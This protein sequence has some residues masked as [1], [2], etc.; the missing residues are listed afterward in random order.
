[1]ILIAGGDLGAHLSEDVFQKISLMLLYYV[2]HQGDICS[3]KLSLRNRDYK[4]YLNSM[5]NLRSDEDRNY[6]SQNEMEDILE[7]I[8]KHLEIPEKQVKE[9]QRKTAVKTEWIP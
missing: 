5:L 6:F 8:R 2:T 1:M 3:S 4:F 9:M 7:A